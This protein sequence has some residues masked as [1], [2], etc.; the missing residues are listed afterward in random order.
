MNTAASS[1]PGN[2]LPRQATDD[3]FPATYGDVLGP[4]D[5]AALPEPLAALHRDSPLF[6][7]W[8]QALDRTT[9]AEKVSSWTTW[10]DLERRAYDSGDVVAFSRVRGY[11]E[12]EIAE[13]LGYLDLTR[14]LD[15]EH[16]DDPDFTFCAMHDVLQT[17]RTPAF[18]ELDARLQALSDTA[19]PPFQR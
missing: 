6:R 4:L 10:T 1:P 15:A 2:A 16:P 11:T 19:P 17:M 8:V 5:I 9:R 7:D 18:D 14:K 3:V 12:A 13:F